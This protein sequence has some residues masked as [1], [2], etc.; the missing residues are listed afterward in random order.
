M[1]FDMAISHTTRE[2]RKTIKAEIGEGK[3][4]TSESKKGTGLTDGRAL[5]GSLGLSWA[6]L[7]LSWILRATI[8]GGHGPFLVRKTFLKYVVWSGTDTSCYS[9]K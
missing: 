4:S 2:Y 9:M 5:L 1:A 8:R 3:D 7:G 6:L